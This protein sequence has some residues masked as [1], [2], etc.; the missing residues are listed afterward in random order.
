MDLQDM[1]RALGP[2][3]ER[4]KKAEAEKAAVLITGSAGGGAVRV[5]ITGALAV[6]QVTIAPAAAAAV[7]DDPT[8]LEDLVAAAFNDALRQ[9]LARFGANAE[10]QMKKSLGGAGAELGPLMGLLGGMPR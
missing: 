3:Q 5:V 10:E 8:M 2:L 7:Q 1:M 6:K 4:M 9:H